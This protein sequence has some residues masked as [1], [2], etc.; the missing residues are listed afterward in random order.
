MP[1]YVP[2]KKN[3]EYIFYINLVSQ[4]DTKLFQINPTLAAGDVKVSTD[5]GAEGNITTLPV[6]TPAG[7]AW[8]KVTLSAAEMNGDNIN[9]K[10]SDVAGAEWCDV[11]FNI[12]TSANQLDSFNF[13]TGNVHVHVKVSDIVIGIKNN[14]AL[15]DFEFLLID[16]TTK[17]PKTGR[18]VTAT[19][20]IDGGAFAACANA[21]SEVAFGIYK[22]NFAASDLNG[23]VVTFRFTA[24]ETVDRLITIV[25]EA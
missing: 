2:P 1:S 18:T 15:N 12:P 8:V 20:S 3:T 16:S 23:K 6:V 22:I 4:A 19:R 25:T 5:G 14:T 17:L 13:T 21:V 24:T 11:G 7:S 9:L 10:F